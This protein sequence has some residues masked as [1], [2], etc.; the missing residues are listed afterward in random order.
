M[1]LSASAAHDFD[2]EGTGGEHGY[3]TKLAIDADRNTEWTTERYQGGQLGKSGVG[4]YL[5][6]RPGTKVRFL[7]VRT[8]TPGFAADVLVADS[9][10]PGQIGGWRRVGRSGRVGRLDDI[11]V[12]AGGKHRWWLL[13]V[14]RLPPGV[15]QVRIA[16]LGLYR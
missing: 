10:P 12:K 3:Q 16:E 11:P 6:A 5:D 9:G 1:P 8:P 13:W 2:P 15:D 4:I 14:T 7:R